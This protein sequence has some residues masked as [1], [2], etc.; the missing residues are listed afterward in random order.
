MKEAEDAL[1]LIKVC[2][3]IA[4]ILVL[5]DFDN[6]FELH[7]EASKV[8]IRAVLSQHGRPMAYCSEKLPG[9]RVRYNTYDVEFYVVV[10]AVRHWCHY[11]FHREFILYTDHDVLKHLHS[12]DKVSTRHASWI[13]YL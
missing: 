1:Q 12:Q 10:Q 5:F 2:L 13:V 11:L 4:P 3:T 9:S 6:P 8:G 7:C